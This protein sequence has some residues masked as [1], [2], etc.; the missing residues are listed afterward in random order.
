MSAPTIVDA[1]REF[2]RRKEVIHDHEKDE[3]LLAVI[4]DEDEQKSLISG[5]DVTLEE[6][7]EI[8]DMHTVSAMIS[9]ANVPIPMI[10]TG[11]WVDGFLAGRI[12]G[13]MQ[14]KYH[15]VKRREATH[16]VR[17]AR[18]LLSVLGTVDWPDQPIEVQASR[19]KLVK[20]LEAYYE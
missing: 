5:S 11:M 19:K 8:A 7:K 18:A 20:A 2:A 15:T 14:T 13:E 4:Y 17:M 9:I 16:V 10:F 3:M 12:Y 1:L 6:L